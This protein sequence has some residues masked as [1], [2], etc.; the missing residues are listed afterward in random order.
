VENKPNFVV[1]SST[2]AFV[3][4]EE[5]VSITISMPKGTT[6]EFVVAALDRALAEAEADDQAAAS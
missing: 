3:G 4:G 6:E 1:T 5:R 2:A